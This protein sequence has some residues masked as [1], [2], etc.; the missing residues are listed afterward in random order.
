MGTDFQERI[1]ELQK[2]LKERY[3]NQEHLKTIFVGYV[4]RGESGRTKY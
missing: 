3:A 2:K 1:E 4:T